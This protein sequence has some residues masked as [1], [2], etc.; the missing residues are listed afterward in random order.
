[1]RSLRLGRDH[2]DISSYFA[3]SQLENKALKS[4]QKYKVSKQLVDK[5][6]LILISMLM[7]FKPKKMIPGLTLSFIQYLCINFCLPVQKKYK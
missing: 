4:T 6:L 3:V 2:F 1:M 7:S 5:E